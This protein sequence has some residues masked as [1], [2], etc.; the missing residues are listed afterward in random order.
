MVAGAAAVAGAGAAL[1]DPAALWAP[2]AGYCLPALALLWLVV[3][4]AV[5]RDERRPGGPGRLD[6]R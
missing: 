1:S 2:A 5:E 4:V 3:D 6:D